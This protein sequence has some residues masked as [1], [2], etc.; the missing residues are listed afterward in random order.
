MEPRPQPIAVGAKGRV[1]GRGHQPGL[2]VI[3][4]FTPATAVVA[5]AGRHPPDSHMTVDDDRRRVLTTLAATVAALTPLLAM[6]W[7]AA[8]STSTGPALVD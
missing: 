1:V 7:S 8:A 2:R 6:P 4:A 3:A 5:L